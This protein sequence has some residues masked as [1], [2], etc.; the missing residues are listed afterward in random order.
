MI[1]ILASF[2][3]YWLSRNFRLGHP[4][5]LNLTFSLLFACNS[6]W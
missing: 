4:L 6:G 3:R 1:R 5:P 2:P